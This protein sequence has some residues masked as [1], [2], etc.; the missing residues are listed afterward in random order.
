MTIT[1]T[2]PEVFETQWDNRPAC[3][4]TEALWLDWQVIDPESGR[5]VDTF[6]TAQDLDDYLDQEALRK[7]EDGYVVWLETRDA[8]YYRWCDQME[9]SLGRVY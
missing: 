9:A 4:C 3:T 8:D 1:E 7:A 6:C 5:S 2:T